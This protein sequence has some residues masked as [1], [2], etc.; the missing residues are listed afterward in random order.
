M[1]AAGLKTEGD[2]PMPAPDN[3]G[4][5]LLVVVAHPHDV[6]HMGGTCAL[7]VDRGDRVSVV[8]MTGGQRTHNEKLAD[9]LRKPPDLR[10]RTVVDGSSED[11]AK[12][13]TG[14]F[15]R[16]CAVFGVT[17]VT[18]L[19]FS[20]HPF[21][22]TDDVVSALADILYDVRPQM[23]LTHSPYTLPDRR[24]H[25][26]WVND[27][28]AAG[29]AVQKALNHV[30]IPDTEGGRAPHRVASIYYTGIDYAFHE[31]DVCIDISDQVSKRIEAETIFE[32]Q[33]HTAEFAKKR[34]ESSA[35]F[36]GWKANT[37]YAE[38]FIRGYREI[39]KCLTVT[40]ENLRLAESSHEER[41]GWIVGRDRR[42]GERP[43]RP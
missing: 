24:F 30:S 14:E 21:E 26:A 25:L 39:S 1:D 36:Q 43:A 5:K 11:Y 42:D 31:V 18:V 4:L 12:R 27:H 23:I 28:T 29:I 38:T 35:G 3:G 20:D 6:C 33:G 41:L 40:E 13:K 19:P 8:A 17:D 10:D 34:I 15:V 22:V 16:A 7:H 2:R 32:S 9:E 37:G